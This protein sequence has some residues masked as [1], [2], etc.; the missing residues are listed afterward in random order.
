MHS[1]RFRLCHY[2]PFFPSADILNFFFFR[3]FFFPS[4]SSYI[5]STFLIL[6]FLFFPSSL[7]CFKLKLTI[8]NNNFFFLSISLIYS[9]TKATCG[10]IFRL[11]I[12]FYILE[13]MKKLFFYLSFSLSLYLP[14]SFTLNYTREITSSTLVWQKNC[15]GNKKIIENAKRRAITRLEIMKYW[16]LMTCHQIQPSHII[17]NHSLFFSFVWIE[18]RKNNERKK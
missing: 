11:I 8:T 2:F 4:R 6:R 16:S 18:K 12:R 5:K 7:S 14:F 1:N 9:N 15:R 13:A 10:M 3:N 17:E